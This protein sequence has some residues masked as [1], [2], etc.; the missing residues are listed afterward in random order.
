MPSSSS[1]DSHDDR[2]AP[3]RV[4]GATLLQAAGRVWG[5]TCTL[6]LLWLA[7]NALRLED[8]GR[9]TFY[10]AVF[11]WL[12]SLANMG[13][14]QV[15]VQWT[16]ADRERPADVL[17]T[18]RRVR[19]A[20]GGLGVVLVAASALAWD[21][22]DA[23]WI[24]LA[25]L[26]PVTHALELST[27]VFHNRI[28]WGVPVAVRA[29]ASG[30]SL[31]GVVLLAARGETRPALY[32]VAV[33]AGSTV[34]NLLLHAAS[35]RLLARDR[36]GAARPV[37]LGGFLRAALPLGLAGLCA[38]T[39]FYVDNLFVRAWRGDDELGLYNLAVRFLSALIMLAQYA[40]LSALPWFTRA[41]ARG[42][43]GAAL[44]RLAAP[45]FVLACLAVGAIW[46][47]GDTLLHLFGPEFTAAAGALRWL[48]GAVLAIYLG[49]LALTAVVATGSVRAP[50][51]I[52]AVGLALNVALNALLV[53][54]HGIDG[55]AAATLATEAWV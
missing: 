21:E 50:L 52:A 15:A 40:S 10:L 53:P 4:W 20:A 36:R 49:A 27:T 24:V 12:D 47:M 35:R 54:R 43:L 14:G 16:A 26:Y 38:Q 19:L 29:V 34:G 11:A 37:P 32:L 5:A 55:A 7:A 23:G 6:T 18:A 8:F 41:H 17:A 25:A 51:V 33:A 39:Y 3:R 42:E 44:A 22:P 13:T 46:S 30:L 28:A 9:F 31:A 2:T 45:V 1:R 48:L